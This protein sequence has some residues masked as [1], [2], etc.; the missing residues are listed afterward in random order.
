M[1]RTFCALAAIAGLLFTHNSFAQKKGGGSL[2]LSTDGLNITLK[3]D[4]L[5]KEKNKFSGSFCLVDVGATIMMDNTNYSDARVTSLLAVPQNR[6]N[7]S[8]FD[9]RTAKSVN[10]NVYPWM[11]KYKAVRT[12]N[13]RIYISSGLGLQLYNFRYENPI[14]FTRNPVAV[15][16]D[17][18][19]FKKNKLALNYLSIPLMVTFKT[20][21]S[22]DNWLVYGAGITEGFLLDSWTKQ[23]SGPRGKVKVY[24][25]FGL[26]DFNTCIS[27]EIGLEGIVRLFA[28]YQVTSLFNNGLD[29]HPVTIGF[30]FG[31]N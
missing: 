7:K 6:Q 22:K 14:T 29:Q 23:E 11:I 13:Q 18:I 17:T 5:K 31:G 20:K 1:K 16:L 2:S 19:S 30:R 3:G 27:A 15:A 12:K 8:L 10:V 4:S 24:D 21:L 28:T 9:M 26:A 25:R